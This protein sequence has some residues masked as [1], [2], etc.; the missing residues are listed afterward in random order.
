MDTFIEYI[1]ISDTGISYVQEN[2][3]VILFLSLLC[4]QGHSGI[5]SIKNLLSSQASVAH[6][7]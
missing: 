1:S 5:A 2:A 6:A 7:S 4:I 3:E